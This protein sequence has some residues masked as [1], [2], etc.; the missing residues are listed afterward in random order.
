MASQESKRLAAVEM[1]VLAKASGEKVRVALALPHLIGGW[2][3]GV[4]IHW[5][6]RVQLC[7]FFLALVSRGVESSSSRGLECGCCV[8][9]AGVAAT[10]AKE[11]TGSAV[12][13]C[14]LRTGCCCCWLLLL[15]VKTGCC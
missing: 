11:R 9:A 1:A 7:V 15:P 14:A 5:P 12:V 4:A 6:G 2:R 8:V 3:S 10:A 13:E